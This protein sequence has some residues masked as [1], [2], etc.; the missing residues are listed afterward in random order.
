MEVAAAN[1]SCHF[2]NELIPDFF[3]RVQFLNGYSGPSGLAIITLNEAMFWVDNGLLK[4]AESQVDDRSWT[5]KEY[6][7]VEEVINWLAKILP[8]KS[9]VGFD[10]TLVSY[11]WH[12]QALQSMTSD[13]FELVAIPG[14]IVDEIWRMRP[15][16]RGDVVK[17][18][19][20]NT[21]EIPVHVK[22][23][24]LRKSLK[25]NKCLAAVITSLE[26]IMCKF[27]FKK[28]PPPPPI[29]V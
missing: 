22:I 4:S 15:F 6:Q 8:P 16:Q 17:M 21:P 29:K 14:N 10:P 27:S 20:K 11:T 5:V 23:D 2:Q 18:L 1:N 26:D 24:R 28:P 7:S 19:D 9:K 3:S 25:P 12:Q 13:R